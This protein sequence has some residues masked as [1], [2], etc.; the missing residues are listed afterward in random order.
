[1]MR[2][3]LGIEEIYI[4]IGYLE[5]QIKD[6][7]GD[8][9]K[10]GVKIRYVM[11]KKLG[12]IGAA[13]YL[14][15]DAIKEKFTVILGD[16]LYIDSN[17]E[18]ILRALNKDFDAIC[19]FI[20]TPDKDKIK[21][22]Y[23]GEF[24]NGRV[25]YLIEKP[26]K[27]T[28]NYLGCGTYILSP[29]IFEYIER[30]TPSSLRNEVEITDVISSMAASERKVYPFFLKGS[31]LN[32][33]NVEDM[34]SANYILR[35]K[36][37]KDYKASV[38]IPACNE[39]ASI[40]KV[41]EEFKTPAVHEIIVVD[42]NSG[43][44]TGELA[45]AGGARVII[46]KKRG[47]GDALKRGMEAAKGEIIILTEADG[48]FRSK[49]IGKILEYLKDA[50]M[51]I[52]TRTTRQM[53][54][55]GSNMGWFLRWGNV[56]LGK[57]IEVLWWRQ[58]PRFTDVGCTS[59]GIWKDS[60]LKIKD[61]LHCSGPEF[62]PEMMIE[63]LKAH[64]RVIE[65]PVSYYKRMGGESKHSAGFKKIKTGLKMLNLILGKKFGWKA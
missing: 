20:E 17:H 40:K 19:C 30:T 7:F 15:K 54:E 13:I 50:D 6:Y 57:F 21:R 2:D 37:F 18:E 24:A 46:E 62:S 63:S 53:I 65:I 60:Y 22:N 36:N 59:R 34:N 55:Q 44:K 28:N 26:Q 16:E 29:K 1:M 10:L 49:D 12:G 47:Y 5:E 61:N 23:S 33:T 43:D 11:Q 8:G 25:K 32:I 3:K 42:N 35:S 41:I 51:V 45:K 58:E 9:S 14:L 4:I 27:P 64:L 38:V 39:E 48:T 52:G 31:Y 56:F